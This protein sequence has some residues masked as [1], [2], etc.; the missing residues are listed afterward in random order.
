MR[1]VH[2]TGSGPESHRWGFVRQ[3]GTVADTLSGASIKRLPAPHLPGRRPFTV[4]DAATMHS[5]AASLTTELKRRNAWALLGFAG[6]AGL[7][8]HEII[9]MKIRDIEVVDGRVFVNIPGKRQ[10]RVPVMHLW[11]RTLLRSIDGRANPDDFVFRGYRWDEYR[12]RVIQSFLSEHPARVRAT[13][14]RLRATWII[15]Q[16]DNGIPL[17]VLKAIAGVSSAHSLDKHLLHA[18]PANINAYVG[19]IIGEEV[20][21]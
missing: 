17:P 8:A 4:A 1:G 21:R 11:N 5:W 3:I 2:P 20:A 10:R 6:G 19:L 7:R 9:E 12:P 13:V 15:A 16:I 14:S 18:K